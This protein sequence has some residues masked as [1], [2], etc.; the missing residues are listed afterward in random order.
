[1]SLVTTAL[2]YFVTFTV[3]I[4]AMLKVFVVA[5]AL[6][7]KL[8]LSNEDYHCIAPILPDIIIGLGCDYEQ[9]IWFSENVPAIDSG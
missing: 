3:P 7:I 2:K 1:M 6:S 5:P 4:S 9:I 8:T